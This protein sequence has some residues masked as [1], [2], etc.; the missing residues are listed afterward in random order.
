MKNNN[1][2]F[3]KMILMF[4]VLFVVICFNVLYKRSYIDIIY[5]LVVTFYFS[6][7]LCLQKNL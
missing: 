7:Y 6:K 2:K 1:K 4:S 3:D 5:L